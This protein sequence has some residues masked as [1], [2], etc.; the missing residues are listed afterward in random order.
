MIFGS[1][2]SVE[3]IQQ[4]A[5]E[6]GK[7]VKLQVSYAKLELTEKLTVLLSTLVLVLVVIILSMVAL[8]YLSFTLV[9]ILAPHV[10][11]L[12]A[13]FGIVTLLIV[14]LIA[15]VFAFRRKLIFEPMVKF[16]SSL[17]LTSGQDNSS[18]ANDTKNIQQP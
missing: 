2:N 18:E 10:G 8:F 11:G 15:G 13:S 1:D 7:L 17:F 3:N 9:Y 16:L 6:I 12:V 14:V 4:L 5:Q